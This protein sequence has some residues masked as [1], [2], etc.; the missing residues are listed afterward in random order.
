MERQRRTEKTT[1]LR[2]AISNRCERLSFQEEK[3][4]TFFDVVSTFHDVP[5]EGE[6]SIAFLNDSEMSDLHERFL[7]DPTPTDVLTFPGDENERFAG[8]ICV[9]AE[10]AWTES[11]SRG[12]SF[13]QEMCLYLVHGWLHLKGY[14]DHS[15][16]D[17]QAMRRAEKE[18]L[19]EVEARRAIP[20]FSMY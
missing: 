12:I 11:V 8:E 18:T 6:L 4:R 15:E 7:Q 3:V 19:G 2:V 13:S 9:S 14:D 16:S 5:L 1:K 20:I 10:R 17:R